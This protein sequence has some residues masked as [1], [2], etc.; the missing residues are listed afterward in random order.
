VRAR[1]AGQWGD[2]FT[3]QAVRRVC[4]GHRQAWRFVGEIPGDRGDFKGAGAAWW[5]PRGSSRRVR[6]AEEFKDHTGHQLSSRY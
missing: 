3:D 2:A 4:A 1:L 6:A 5:L